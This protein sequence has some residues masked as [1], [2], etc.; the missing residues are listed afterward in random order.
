MFGIQRTAWQKR[1]TKQ[2]IESLTFC[3]SVYICIS[4]KYRE[5]KEQGQ[6]GCVLGL[7]ACT[8][9]LPHLRGGEKKLTLFIVFCPTLCQQGNYREKIFQ[10]N[11]KELFQCNYKEIFQRELQ[12]EEQK[13]PGL[14][15]FQNWKNS[16]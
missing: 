14:V 9:Q 10:C 7:F 15:P 6:L 4:I 1:K 16:Q 8:T 3:I 12:T 11:Y 5:G 2:Q 13:K